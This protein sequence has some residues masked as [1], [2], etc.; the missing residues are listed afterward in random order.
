MTGTGA[1]AT[2]QVTVT[3]AGTSARIG[4]VSPWGTKSLAGAVLACLVFWRR[5]K[6]TGWPVLLVVGAVCLGLSGCG[7]S[8][9]GGA[10]GGSGSDGGSSG[11]GIYTITVGA[12]APGISHSVT[13]NL[14]VE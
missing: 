3:T 11:Q 1:T 6:W 8:I 4:G 9:N 10:G 2:V 14:T 13:L 5:R 12:G 7:L